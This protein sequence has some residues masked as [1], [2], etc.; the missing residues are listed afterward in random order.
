[1]KRNIFKIMLALTLL[2]CVLPLAVSAEGEETSCSKHQWV[3]TGDT[4]NCGAAGYTS[5]L[6]TGCGLTTTHD[7]PVNPNVHAGQVTVSEVPAKCGIAGEVK[8][9]CS[10]GAQT[11]TVSTGALSHNWDNGVVVTAATCT[12]AGTKEYTCQNPGCPLGKVVQAYDAL[13]H[14]WDDGVGS[15]AICGRAG[16]KVFTCLRD[17][18]HTKTETYPALT[19]NWDEGVVITAATCTEAGTKEY[20]CQNAGCLLGKVTQ[21]YDALGHDWDDGVGTNAICGQAGQKV[22]TCSRDASHTKTENYPALRH[23]WDEG[24]IVKAATC[25]EK[26]SKYYTCQNPGCPLG[27]VTQAYDAL[28]HAWDEGKVTKAATCSAKGVKTYTCT[29][30][31]AH[32]KTE[33]IPSTGGHKL[34]A[35]VYD[36]G[37]HWQYC[38]NSGCKYTVS[39]FH[40]FSNWRVARKATAEE[41]GVLRKDCAYC[42]QKLWSSYEYSDNPKTDDPL[43]PMMALLLAS[44]ALLPMV[45]RYTRRKWKYWV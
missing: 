8:Y 30:N 41:D 13:G 26:G 9:S 39:A 31:A 32:T 16:E 7:V 23:N 2:V 17:T 11:W 6:C 28:G 15:D 37:Q 29:R 3:Q 4:S 35:M 43:V 1:M 33:N 18:S 10:C 24:V 44:A 38:L 12:E 5:W 19:H 14:L 20:T 27:N 21:A 22:F 40:E 25:T 34:S 45:L 36:K 42:G